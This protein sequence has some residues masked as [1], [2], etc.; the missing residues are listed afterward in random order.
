MTQDAFEAVD[1]PPRRLRVGED[2]FACTDVGAGE[3]V[4]FLHGALGDRRTWR[5][6]CAALAGRFR[7]LAYT[8]RHFGT[9]PWRADGPPFGTR[10]HADDLVA[11]SEALGAG[12]VAVVAWSYAGHAALLAALA[13]PDLFSRVLVYEP[14]VPSWVSDPAELDAHGRDAEAMF[15]PVFE[16]AGRGDVEDA[17]R[18]LIEA[19]GGPGCFERRSA[20]RRAIEIDNAHTMPLLLAQEPPPPIGCDDLRALRVPATVAWGERT[21]PVFRIPSRAA[22]RCLGPGRGVEVPGAGHLWPDEDPAGFAAL[23]GDWM[24]RATGPADPA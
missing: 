18:R 10:A 5:R 9:E 8:Q 13:R 6:H 22:A 4:L 2:A 3:P 15:G 16:A 21:R 7:C 11:F 24:D 17:V 14:G 20:D 23:V 12:A 19:S 1:A